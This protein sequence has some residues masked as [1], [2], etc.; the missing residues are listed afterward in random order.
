MDQSRPGD[1]EVARHFDAQVRFEPF[2]TY[3]RLRE[4]DRPTFRKLVR[5]VRATLP[6]AGVNA[7]QRALDRLDD[8]IAGPTRLDYARVWEEIVA[9]PLPS[10]RVVFPGAFVDWDNTPRYRRH[11]TLFDGA[12]PA[13]FEAGVRRLAARLS[14]RRAEERLLF[15]NAWNEWAEGAYLEP[16]TQMG[17]AW[18]SA[19]GRVIA[20]QKQA[21]GDRQQ[22]TG[23]G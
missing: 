4:R 6:A 14:E 21:T 13:I 9:R 15:V 17:T 5:A 3:Y 20:E 23:N 12:T 1:D 2:S 19:L 11:A 22:A 7:V 10:D 16:D 18:I 8:L